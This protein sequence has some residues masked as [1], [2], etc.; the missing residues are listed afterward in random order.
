MWMQFYVMTR[1]HV[2]QFTL[3]HLAKCHST[4]SYIMSINFPMSGFKATVCASTG[5]YQHNC[6]LPDEKGM[7]ANVDWKYYEKRRA[8]QN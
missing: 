8:T 6:A 5:D 2:R 4:I 3:V 7:K 1:T